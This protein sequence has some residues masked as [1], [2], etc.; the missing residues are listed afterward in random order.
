M[1][2]FKT[3]KNLWIN[4]RKGFSKGVSIIALAISA[5]APGNISFA[6]D[7]EE[8]TI[9]AGRYT[10]SR[11]M[12]AVGSGIKGREIK[13]IDPII[14]AYQK[15]HPNVKINVLGQS[16][17]SDTRQWMITNLTAETAPEIMWHLGDWAVE[18]Y[19]KNWTVP[20]N[21]YLEMPNP[22]IDE[23]K[24]G[25]AKWRDL[26]YDTIDV[27]TA[28]NDDKYIVLADQIQVAVYY[29][30]DLFKKAG[31]N[32]VPETWEDMMNAAKLVQETG[33]AG[34]A[35]YGN[36][37]NQ[38][39]WIS[40]WLTNYFYYPEISTYDT[41]KDGVLNKIEMANAVKAGTYKFDDPRNKARLK[42]LKRY[43]SYSQNGASGA[44]ASTATRLFLTGRAGMYVVGTWMLNTITDDKD[45]N[46]D[47]G[48]FY[49]PNVNSS[50]SELIPDNVPPTNKS[51]GY[52]SFQYTVTNSAV[53]NGTVDRAMDFLMFATQ[54]EQISPM[55]L[56]G[57]I[58]IPS[59]HGATPNPGLSAFSETVTYPSAPFQ[60]DDSMFDYNFAEKF[61]AI[62]SPYMYGNQSLSDTVQ[63]LDQEMTAA[64][65]RVLGN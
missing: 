54:P 9:W 22:Y 29:N 27:W 52:G 3:T 50:T 63:R 18:D 51:A 23:G 38:L 1:W 21:K 45:R 55:I 25:S 44:D 11:T 33:A 4:Y 10:P 60:E 14:E 36:D 28:P 64:A 62:T 26:F 30:K 5:V 7:T 13:G 65:D 15:L 41:S 8:L 46:F 32:G 16:I 31:V 49:L 42:E 48:V 17:N 61:L 24:K 39:T 53:K 58:G 6:S 20:I 59:I 47:F 37:L 34:F 43:A 40:G 12:A 2:N 35:T 57:N 19:R 56:E